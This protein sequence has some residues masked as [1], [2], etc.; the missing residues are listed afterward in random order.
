[1]LGAVVSIPGYRMGENMV[2]NYS[3]CNRV[4]EASGMIVTDPHPTILKAQTYF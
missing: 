4:W 3:D 1:M 2:K